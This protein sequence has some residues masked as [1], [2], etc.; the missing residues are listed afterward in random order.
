MD[1]IPMR[2]YIDSNKVWTELVKI[3]RSKMSD[4][5]IHIN[6]PMSTTC[7]LANMSRFLQSLEHC[8]GENAEKLHNNLK[9]SKLKTKGFGIDP[10]SR[11]VVMVV[12]SSFKGHLGNWAPNHAEEIL[13]LDNIDALTSYVRVGFF[14]M[15]TWRV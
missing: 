8:S 4:R 12:V 10:N 14:S 3:L 5:E 6:G 11:E 7:P 9:S 1:N 15:K 2:D 13:K